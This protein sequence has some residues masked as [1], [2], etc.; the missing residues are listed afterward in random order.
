MEKRHGGQR[1]PELEGGAQRVGGVARAPDPAPGTREAVR[2]VDQRDPRD[3][4]GQKEYGE[5]P[6]DLVANFV[7]PY[8][9]N[10][11]SEHVEGYP[12]D[13]QTF[14]VGEILCEEA[15]CSAHS[16][17]PLSH[18]YSDLARLV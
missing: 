17:P 5:C 1:D 6:G 16:I 8:F 3:H 11:D 18:R 2:V 4:G 7:E 12:H 9:E 10:G 14:G 15:Y 13:C